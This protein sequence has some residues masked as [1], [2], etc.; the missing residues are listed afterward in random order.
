MNI[1]KILLVCLSVIFVMTLASC[2]SNLLKEAESQY[3]S[4]EYEKVIDTLSSASKVKNKSGVYSL[5][6]MSYMQLDDYE[7]AYSAFSRAIEENP[8]IH[9]NYLNRAIA[10]FN[11]GENDRAEIHF[12]EAISRIE[13]LNNEDSMLLLIENYAS[14]LVINEKY[15][16]A[17]EILDINKILFIDSASIYDIRYKA[18]SMLKKNDEAFKTL[19]EGLEKY[20]DDANLNYI[21]ALNRLDSGDYQ[22]SIKYLD[23]VKITDKPDIYYYKAIAY[24]LMD[25]FDK[26]YNSISEHLEKNSDDAQAY[27]QKGIILNEQKKF[28]R[29]IKQFDKTLSLDSSINEVNYY[30]AI[31]YE[32]L[33]KYNKALECLEKV[34]ESSEVYDFAI[35]EIDFVKDNFL[36]K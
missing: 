14:L 3:R 6:G 19:S 33:K 21:M 30:K 7:K 24:R 27:L 18:L 1:K 9:E 10:S 20:S 32:G 13:K 22:N 8:H 31:S 11:L 17:L 29:A 26:A 12:E 34:D 15:E 5:K 4:G 2:S 25:D 23:R 28:K 16:R 36:K 35:E